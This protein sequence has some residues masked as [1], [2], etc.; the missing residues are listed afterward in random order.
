MIYGITEN[1]RPTGKCVKNA[2]GAWG[3]TPIRQVYVLHFYRTVRWLTAE[4]N[5]NA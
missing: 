3:L 2:P 5:K 1:P 4:K